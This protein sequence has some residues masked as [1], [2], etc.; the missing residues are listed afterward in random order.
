MYLPSLVCMHTCT[1]CILHLRIDRSIYS[2]TPEYNV[3]S[4]SGVCNFELRIPAA[5]PMPHPR[6]VFVGI[7]II[8]YPVI[9]LY[10]SL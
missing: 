5:D 7:I 9:V 10:M 4:G 6:L 2:M 3:T 8:S 1:T